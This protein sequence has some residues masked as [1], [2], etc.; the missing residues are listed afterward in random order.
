M[1]LRVACGG[2]AQQVGFNDPSSVFPIETASFVGTMYFRLRG[3][4]GEP[5]AYFMGRNR[6]L[7]AVVQGRVKRPIPMSE[8][9]TGYEFQRPFKN[10]PAKWLLSGAMRFVRKLAPTLVEDVLGPRP[11]ILNPLFQTIQVMDVALPGEEPNICGNNLMEEN[12]RLG[13]MFADRRVDRLERKKYFASAKNGARH[14]LQPSLVYTMEFYEDKI[15]PRAFE[16]AIIGMRFSLARYLSGQP[17]QILGK[18]GTIPHT[19]DY[20]FNVE[21]WHENLVKEPSSGSRE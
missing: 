1:M 6:Q 2:T 7:S 11:Y 14:M 9:M 13:G 21:I 8:C 5:T 12:S 18:L 15:N 16:L 20:L 3:L 19:T 10:V 17:L 4:E